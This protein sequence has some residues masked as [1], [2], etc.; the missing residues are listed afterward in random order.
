MH[1]VAVHILATSRHF[2]TL[3]FEAMLAILR[4]CDNNMELNCDKST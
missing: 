1:E 3:S 4:G 2:S